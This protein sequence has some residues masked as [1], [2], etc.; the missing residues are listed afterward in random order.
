VLLPLAATASDARPASPP[1]RLRDVLT[2][3]RPERDRDTRYREGR[4]IANEISHWV[5]GLRVPESDG[6][7]AA[8]WSDVLLLVR[9][10]T[11][12]ADYER[13]LR[14]AGVPFVSDRRGGLL[15]TLEADDLTALLGFLIAPFADLKLAH[16]R[17]SPIFD[18]SDDDL[19][20][21][22]ARTERTW[23]QRLQ[24]LDDEGAENLMRARRLLARWL[25]L[26][27]VLPA[28]DLLDR[29]Y[30][31]GD[32]RRRYAAAAPAALH[33][34]VQANL[35]AFIELALQIDAG[36]YPSLPRFIDELAGLKRY[37]SDEA[38]DEGAADGGDAVVCALRETEEEIGL[39]QNRVTVL[40]CLSERSSRTGFRVTPVIGLVQP[41]FDLALDDFEVAEVFEVPLDFLVDAG[42]RQLQR[43]VHEGRERSFWSILWEGRNIWG[44]TAAILVTLVDELASGAASR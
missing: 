39:A 41:P 42:N 34:Q 38:P 17:R 33:A 43:V 16:A 23:W 22:A 12:L 37:A 14:D 2:T 36:R 19:M 8:R 13:A 32:V 31:E 6:L 3:P 9:R 5:A 15:A 24:A 10:R 11:Y 44:L 21:L 7:R 40:G 29:I 4:V 26:A 20:R 1:D 27:G 28:H 30:F 35:D 25:D 18:C